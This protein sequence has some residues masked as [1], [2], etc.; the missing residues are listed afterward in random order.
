VGEVKFGLSR[1]ANR[2]I[3]VWSSLSQNLVKTELD[4]MSA[5]WFKTQHESKVWT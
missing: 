4:L 5:I 3:K 1:K 2:L